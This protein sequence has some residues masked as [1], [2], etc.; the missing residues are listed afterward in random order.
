MCHKITILRNHP[1]N[2]IIEGPTHKRLLKVAW[3]EDHIFFC[4]SIRTLVLI[5]DQ[6]KLAI[7]GWKSSKIF[8]SQPKRSQVSRDFITVFLANVL[9]SYIHLFPRFT[10]SQL[11][12]IIQWDKLFPFSLYSIS[13]EVTFFSRSAT[14]QNRLLTGFFLGRYNLSLFISRFIGS[15]FIYLKY[16]SNSQVLTFPL[17]FIH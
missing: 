6:D 8:Y 3:L 14:L 10:P 13:K 9:T 12:P 7:K 2:F 17:I 16:P 1:V 5:L 4:K 15:T 11:R